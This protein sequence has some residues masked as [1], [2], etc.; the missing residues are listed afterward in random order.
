MT[1]TSASR[2]SRM[3][4][5]R[6][7]GSLKPQPGPHTAGPE[8]AEELLSQP[9]KERGRQRAVV[10][11]RRQCA[12]HRAHIRTRPL[13]LV[14]M[15][16]D[17]PRAVAVETEALFRRPGQLQRPRWVVRCT[18]LSPVPHATASCRLRA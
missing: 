2:R 4:A 18:V 10:D 14:G 8:Q 13:E 5:P 12:R 9:R 11:C 16:E 1:V 17:D 3:P 15:V 6:R 7:V